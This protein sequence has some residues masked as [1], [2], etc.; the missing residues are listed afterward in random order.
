MQDV[1]SQPS[2]FGLPLGVVFIIFWAVTMINN[3]NDKNAENLRSDSA[4]KSKSRATSSNLVNCRTCG[5]D[6]SK[7][8]TACPHC[9]E[10]NFKPVS[11]VTRSHHVTR[12]Q[13]P[14]VVKTHQKYKTKSP[15]YYKERNLRKR[16][17]KDFGEAMRKQIALSSYYYYDVV[18]NEVKGPLAKQDLGV[19]EARNEI[20]ELTQVCKEGS[21]DWIAYKE[22]K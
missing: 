22:I 11:H 16:K 2:A 19:L 14:S 17:N 1:W 5:R 21:S 12:S 3:N 10:P 13:K 18:N 8:V 20:D 6:V 4:S 7:N 9:G 15:E